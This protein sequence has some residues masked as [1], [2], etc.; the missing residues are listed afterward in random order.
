MKK[1][2]FYTFLAFFLTFSSN[3]KAQSKK[4]SDST[5]TDFS[6]GIHFGLQTPQAD[7]AKTFGNNFNAGLHTEFFWW[8]SRWFVGGG[9]Q[10]LFGE[11][12]KIDP[13][14]ALR[15]S[16]GLLLGNG[17]FAEIELRERGA[18]ID[19]YVGH[20]I[21]IRDNGNQLSGLRVTLGVGFL[22]H[23][24]RIQDNQNNVTPQVLGVYRNGYDRLTNGLALTQFIG[25]EIRSR[26][27]TINFYAGFDFTEGFTKNRRGYNFD[28]RQRDDAQRLDVLIG[29]RAGLLL[30]IF[31]S[32]NASEYEY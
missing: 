31:S 12:L 20:L 23:Y 4:L 14:T 24:I 13:L 9:G 29:F 30:P 3:L 2:I 28:T 25:Y 7:L 21:K 22:E 18:V 32:R 1:I 10:F 19:A 17:A 27:K 16:E 11:T 15:S 26:N 6:V 5:L 8:N